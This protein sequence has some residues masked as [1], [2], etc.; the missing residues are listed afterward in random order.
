MA[1]DFR[2]DVPAH[3][4][5]TTLKA[6]SDER[7]RRWQQRGL[8]NDKRFAEKVRMG[9]AALAVTGAITTAISLWLA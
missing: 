9:L 2:F 5:Q 8:D 3:Q 6:E 1:H 4:T 7:W